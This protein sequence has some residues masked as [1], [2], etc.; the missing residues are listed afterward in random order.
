M[1]AVNNPSEEETKIMQ[2]ARWILYGTGSEKDDFGKELNEIVNN[3][4]KKFKRYLK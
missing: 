1:K 3:I 4:R 2:K